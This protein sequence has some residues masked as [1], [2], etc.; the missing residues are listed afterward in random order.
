MATN[1][2]TPS[3]EKRDVEALYALFLTRAR[4]LGAEVH[5]VQNPADAGKLI[6]DLLH[7]E[8]V[9]RV[10]VAGTPI[11]KSLDIHALVGAAGAEV[12]AGNARE[13]A[14]PADLGISFFEMAIAE[15]GTL[16]QD[17]TDINRRLVSMLPPVHVALAPTTGLVG[18]LREAIDYLAARGE[19]PGYLAFV[20]GPSRTADIERVLTIGVHGPG[21]VYVIFMDEG[22]ESR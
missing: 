18:T 1:A 4:A 9:R 17:A 15:T 5:R 3:Q 19:I 11:V 13:Q 16:V 8:N 12:T 20:S 14:E 6:Q 10:A 21:K 7:R 2:V 22:G